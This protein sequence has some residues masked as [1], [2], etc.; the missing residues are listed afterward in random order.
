MGSH[1][2]RE[3]SAVLERRKMRMPSVAGRSPR[4]HWVRRFPGAHPSRGEVRQGRKCR[5]ERFETQK[6]LSSE[7]YDR[8][9]VVGKSGR[10]TLNKGERISYV[11]DGGVARIVFSRPEASN[12]VD[13][14]FAR[15]FE[16]AARAA[17]SGGARVVF[18]SALGRHFCVGGDLKSFSAAA[19]LGNHL[20]EVTGHLHEGI[21]ML[22]E[23]DAPVVV[24]VNGTA[25]GAGFGLVCAADIVVAGESAAFLM[26]YT[27]LGLSPDG[28][29]SWFLPRHVGLRRAMDMSLTNRILSAPEALGWGIVSRVVA[30]DAVTSEAEEIVSVLAHGPTSAY[31]ATARLLRSSGGNSLRTHLELESATMAERARARDAREGIQSFLEHRDARF[32]GD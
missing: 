9:R 31:G 21:A 14:T 19:D 32:T 17:M 4:S 12:A 24:A 23:L 18:V 25:A 2:A 28:S 8:V 15:E 29:S 5:L 20:K 16:V 27:R 10:L 6:P 7:V 22:V 3:S 13:L 1:D 30:D 26:A 11:V